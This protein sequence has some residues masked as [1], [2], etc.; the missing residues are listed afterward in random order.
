MLSNTVPDHTVCPLLKYKRP[1][2][3]PNEQTLRRLAVPTSSHPIS[4]VAPVTHLSPTLPTP[5]S[6]HRKSLPA[7]QAAHACAR[8]RAWALLL[9]SGKPLLCSPSLS[10]WKI[11]A[12]SAR[13]NSRALHQAERGRGPFPHVPQP[14]WVTPTKALPTLPSHHLLTDPPPLCHIC[15]P[16]LMWRPTQKRMIRAVG[17]NTIT[18]SPGKVRLSSTW[19][20]E[21]WVGLTGARAAWHS[22]ISYCPEPSSSLGKSSL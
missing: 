13:V 20:T 22:A 18:N 7:P 11:A 1:L 8:L 17:K 3:P 2:K 19:R 21:L 12:Y 10:A 14:P 4:Q 9:L 16:A 15:D 6:N 5:C